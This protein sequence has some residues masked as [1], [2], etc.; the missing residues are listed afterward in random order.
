M[1]N[2]K[3]IVWDHKNNI[4]PKLSNMGS[5]I[6][7][8][9]DCNEIWVLRGQW[10]IPSKN[11]PKYPAPAPPPPPLPLFFPW[12]NF[13]ITFTFSDHPFWRPGQTVLCNKK[14]IENVA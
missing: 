9:K 14:N 8:R 12:G 1:H 7:H 10:H 11:S 2:Q 3:L 13:M 6:G 5:M 4:C